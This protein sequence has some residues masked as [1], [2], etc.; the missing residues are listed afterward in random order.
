MVPEVGM[1]YA[2]ED[3]TQ[4]PEFFINE[5][6][7][8]R[9]RNALTA[10]FRVDGRKLRAGEK[11]PGVGGRP[12]IYDGEETGLLQITL[13]VSVIQKLR[14]GGSPSEAIKEKVIG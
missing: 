11:R 2:V 13:P 12:P 3:D 8:L 4:M 5:L 14:A 1:T 10:Q 7:R 6:A 9:K